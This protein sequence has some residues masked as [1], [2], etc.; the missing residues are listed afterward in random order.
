ML[1]NIPEL[2]VIGEDALR[3]SI[4]RPPLLHSLRE[5]GTFLRSKRNVWL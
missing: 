5:S 2:M 3:D 1:R 4:E